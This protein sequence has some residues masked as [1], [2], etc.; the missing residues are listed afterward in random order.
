MCDSSRKWNFHRI[1]FDVDILALQQIPV[2]RYRFWILVHGFISI[3]LLRYDTG[4]FSDLNYAMVTLNACR[5]LYWFVR[6]KAAREMHWKIHSILVVCCETKKKY[7]I[8]MA[9]VQLWVCC[10]AENTWK[11]YNYFVQWNRWINCNWHTWGFVVSVYIR[12]E[13]NIDTIDDDIVS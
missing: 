2:T 4:G 12:F 5:L 1:H 8:T 6:N 10:L 7:L 3:W 13:V 11:D 9:Y